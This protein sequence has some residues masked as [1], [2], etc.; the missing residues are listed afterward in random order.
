MLAIVAG[1]VLVLHHNSDD[2][3][4]P[5]VAQQTAREA[6]RVYATKYSSTTYMSEYYLYVAAEN[7]VVSIR[8]SQT[9]Q[10]YSSCE[11][12]IAAIFENPVDVC[13]WDFYFVSPFKKQRKT[14]R[15]VDK[16]FLF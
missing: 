2:E 9:Q 5:V 6:Y 3:V 13:R 1:V 16:S 4:D 11:E 12:A 14:P 7:C 10:V 15:K 8:N